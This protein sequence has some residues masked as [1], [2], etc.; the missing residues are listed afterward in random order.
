MSGRSVTLVK[1]FLDKPPTD[2]LSVLS[3]LNIFT[4][5]LH[6]KFYVPLESV[7]R[8]NDRRNATMIVDHRPA[9]GFEFLNPL[10]FSP[11]LY[12]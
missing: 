8:K 10:L 9:V 2:R 1:L 3:S 11:I 5:S 4:T 12:H 6:A 7:K